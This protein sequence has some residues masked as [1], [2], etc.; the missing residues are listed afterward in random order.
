MAGVVAML[1]GKGCQI[2]SAVMQRIFPSHSHG[3]QD[4]Y[5]NGAGRLVPSS[6][7]NSPEVKQSPPSVFINRFSRDPTVFY[8][9]SRDSNVTN[10]GQ[11]QKYPREE[12]KATHPTGA[13]QVK[14]SERAP[15][16]EPVPKSK[17]SM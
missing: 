4:Q 17:A 16:S 7:S 2:H 15:R 9:F 13:C 11:K 10:A 12:L 5:E 8:R 1:H 14:S 6:Y 3:L